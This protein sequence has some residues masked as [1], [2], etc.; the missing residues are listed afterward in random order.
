LGAGP[1]GLWHTR[2]DVPDSYQRFWLDEN[3]NLVKS[4]ECSDPGPDGLWFTADDVV[5][6]TIRYDTTR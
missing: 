4:T 5:S 3:D 6:G 1:D 2:D